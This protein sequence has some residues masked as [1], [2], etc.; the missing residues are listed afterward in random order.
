MWNKKWKKKQTNYTGSI[1]EDRKYLHVRLIQ[2]E[3]KHGRWQT[4]RHI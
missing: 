2:A 3:V 4:G 1:N